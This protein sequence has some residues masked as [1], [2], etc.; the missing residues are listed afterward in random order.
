MLCKRIKFVPLSLTLMSLESIRPVSLLTAASSPP[1][2]VT[3]SCDTSSMAKKICISK[4]SLR[5]LL[6]DFT[7]V[8]TVTLEMRLMPSSALWVARKYAA[9]APIGE[10]GGSQYGFNL[11]PQPEI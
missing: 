6:G 5:F 11:Q 2:F 1:G 3:W 7:L 10:A 8:T 4:G 9:V